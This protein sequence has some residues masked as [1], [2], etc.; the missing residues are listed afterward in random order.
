MESKR[1]RKQ[2]TNQNA[3]I[4]GAGIGIKKRTKSKL[5]Q[6]SGI[7]CLLVL[8]GP[9]L[10]RFRSYGDSDV[11][12]DSLCSIT[13]YKLARHCWHR[14]LAERHRDERLS[15]RTRLEITVYDDISLIFVVSCCDRV[16]VAISLSVTNCGDWLNPIGQSKSNLVT[17]AACDGVVV[18]IDCDSPDV[19]V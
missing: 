15:D 8:V 18:G 13:L 2:A 3:D 12:N 6:G 5:R 17:I 14:S 19:T 11:A 16:N 10:T 9:R 1:R 7:W 4:F